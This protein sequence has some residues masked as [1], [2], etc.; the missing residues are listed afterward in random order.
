SRARSTSSSPPAERLRGRRCKR[1]AVVAES[2]AR[3]PLSMML[4]TQAVGFRAI[5]ERLD[6]GHAGR[7]PLALAPRA[8]QLHDNHFF[9]GSP[10]SGRK[11]GATRTRAADHPPR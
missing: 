2:Q 1:V 11:I 10:P 8:F 7:T 4:K 6:V 9:L 3:E 5:V